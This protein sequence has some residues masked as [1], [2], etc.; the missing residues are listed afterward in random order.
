[1]VASVSNSVGLLYNGNITIP[2]KKLSD[3]NPIQQ[4]NLISSIKSSYSSELGINENRINVTLSN[5][6]IIVTVDVYYTQEQASSAHVYNNL[7]I[8]EIR[9]ITDN[10]YRFTGIENILHSNNGVVE[11]DLPINTVTDTGLKYVVQVTNNSGSIYNPSLNGSIQLRIA[12]VTS[13]NII[14]EHGFTYSENVN[15]EHSNARF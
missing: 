14:Y 8:D 7:F 13:E 10:G 11:D 4:T 2:E 5:G 15:I 6:S 1:M 3:I 12:T 9:I